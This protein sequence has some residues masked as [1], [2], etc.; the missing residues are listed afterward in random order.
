MQLYERRHCTMT[1]IQMPRAY[2][3]NEQ[4]D[5]ACVVADAAQPMSQSFML[6]WTGDSSWDDDDDDDLDDADEDA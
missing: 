4:N 2:P 3:I 6:L 5:G 1:F